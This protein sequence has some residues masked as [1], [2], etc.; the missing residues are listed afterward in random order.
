[1][2]QEDVQYLYTVYSIC[3]VAAELMNQSR[4][5]KIGLRTIQRSP[6]EDTY[7]TLR[8]YLPVGHV[9]LISFLLG[10]ASL[11][12]FVFLSTCQPSNS[13]PS[14]PVSKTYSISLHVSTA[15]LVF[16]LCPL[17]LE[18]LPSLPVSSS[19]VLSIIIQYCQYSGRIPSEL[20][21]NTTTSWR[22][23]R[24]PTVRYETTILA[25]YESNNMIFDVSTWHQ[26]LYTFCVYFAAVASSP[27]ITTAPS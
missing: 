8:A 24:L 9:R 20:F 3:T 19:M 12:C 23:H 16:Y 1:M 15:A 25:R 14:G 6:A 18:A 4:T 21:E 13:S 7:I 22:V 2:K 5:R 11:C 17:N 10:L 26:Q 27:R